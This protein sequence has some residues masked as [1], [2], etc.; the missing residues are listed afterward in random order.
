LDI[1]DKEF[2]VSG[3]LV[4]ELNWIKNTK[5]G[6]YITYETFTNAKTMTVQSG[7]K[8]VILARQIKT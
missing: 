3:K 8:E 5:S 6:N 2:R 1:V 7:G 4:Y